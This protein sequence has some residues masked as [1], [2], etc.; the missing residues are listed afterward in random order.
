MLKSLPEMTRAAQNE[1]LSKALSAQAEVTRQHV[2]TFQC[3]CFNPLARVRK[4]LPARRSSACS[5]NRRTS[6]GDRQVRPGARCWPN[7]QPASR[8]A[9]RDRPL[10]HAPRVGHRRRTAA[11]GDFAP[12]NGREREAGR[13][14]VEPTR[15]PRRQPIRFRNRLIAEREEL[16]PRHDCPQLHPRVGKCD[17]SRPGQQRSGA[18]QSST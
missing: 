12:P 7:L 5:R 13:R 3:R 1:A 6:E 10:R 2:K 18:G 16:R 15:D 4:A 11:G 14:R 9:L 17:A 8:A